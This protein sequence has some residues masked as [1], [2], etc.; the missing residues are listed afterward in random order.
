MSLM[1]TYELRHSLHLSQLKNGRYFCKTH[2]ATPV[3]IMGVF[4]LIVASLK[5]VVR[6]ELA[7]AYHQREKGS[8]FRSIYISSRFSC[9]WR[10]H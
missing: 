5:A 10:L 4:K 8:P 2:L 3:T 6:C 7:Y 9:Q 1:R